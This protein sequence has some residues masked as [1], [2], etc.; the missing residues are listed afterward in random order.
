MNIAK[1]FRIPTPKNISKMLEVSEAV[2]KTVSN[3]LKLF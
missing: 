2:F 3:Y 1:F